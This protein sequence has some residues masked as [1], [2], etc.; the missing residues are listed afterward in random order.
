M[1]RS[2]IATAAAVLFALA[3]SATAQPIF[4]APDPDPFYAAPADLD[5]A[6]PGE[7]LAVRSMPGLLTFPGATVTMIK[8]RSSNSTGRP[9]AATTTVLTP[10][11]HTQGGP[12]LSYQ[13]IINGL[14]TQC[15]VSRVLYTN[16]PNLA[17]REAPALNA[18][19]LRG[20]SVALP[21]HLGPTSAYGAAKLGGT[22]TL[23]GIRAARRVA[24]LGL[25]DSPVA[26]LG[27]SGGGMA[28][29]WAA[30]LAPTYAPD[31]PLVGAAAGGV[32][33]NLVEM[34]EGLGYTRHAAFGLAFAA[35]IGLER[36]YP[37]RLPISDHL[38]SF[39]MAVRDRI[40]NSCTN[41]IL[42][43]GAGRSVVDV[44]TSVSLVDDE[45][46]LAVL[47]ENSL[48]LYDGI[49]TTPVFQWRAVND[50]LVPVASMDS[51]IRRYCAAGVRLQYEMLPSPD[52][53]STAVLGVPSALGWLDA[54]FRG[55]PAPSNC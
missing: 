9:I 27:Y 26:M 23:D 44:A 51:T 3:P 30:A 4:P 10:P 32:P 1:L 50:A 16:D 54:R 29:A 49:P 11:N 45:R 37:A 7:V 41:E 38:N 33:M 55:M 43:A 40:A 5:A 34:I 8:F 28:T 21:D 36:E 52:H 46:A 48:E 35:A 31:L 24:E 22:I 14:G 19:L 47:E 42:L 12:L 39:G 18:V 2:G 53:L 6:A 20:W 17:V 13:H 15:A 25:A